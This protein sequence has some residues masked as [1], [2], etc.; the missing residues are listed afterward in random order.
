[1]KWVKVPGAGALRAGGF[2]YPK[3][4]QLIRVVWLDDTTHT[5]NN[6]AIHI[7]QTNPNSSYVYLE[8]NPRQHKRDAQENRMTLCRRLS[9]HLAVHHRIPP[10]TLPRMSLLDCASLRLA[11]CLF[12]HRSLRLLTSRH[13]TD[14]PQH[15]SET[16]TFRT[17]PCSFIL[18]LFH[19]CSAV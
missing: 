15:R 19:F 6:T 16:A 5:N 7:S 13:S 2:S 1:M 14:S 3:N 4:R 10:L 18:R 8:S 9:Y 12:L 11:L 17:T